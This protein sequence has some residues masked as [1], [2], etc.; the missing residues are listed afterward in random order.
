MT[1]RPPVLEKDGRTYLSCVECG[2]RL[3]RYEGE[4][5]CPDCMTTGASMTQT[6]NSPAETHAT[7][8]SR[9]HAAGD[10]RERL[11][12]WA[13]DLHDQRGQVGRLWLCASCLHTLGQRLMA[14]M[15]PG[16][17]QAWL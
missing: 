10:M 16:Q 7:Q 4:I 14:M 9:C 2:S 12:L 15:A 5:Y 11:A 8:C 6:P 1:R 3:W 17:L 13:F